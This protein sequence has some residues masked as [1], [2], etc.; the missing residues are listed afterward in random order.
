MKTLGQ[1]LR[2]SLENSQTIN[3]AKSVNVYAGFSIGSNIG[4]HDASGCTFC[5]IACPEKLAKVLHGLRFNIST[6]A[7]LSNNWTK[8]LKPSELKAYKE[9]LE[10]C[11]KSLMGDVITNTQQISLIWFTMGGVPK[12]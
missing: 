11:R 8:M 4:M 6:R 10:M 5:E 1:M 2:E 9:W 7:Y 12:R 3:E